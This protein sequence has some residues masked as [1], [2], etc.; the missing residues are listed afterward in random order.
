MIHFTSLV[1]DMA[2]LLCKNHI[3][4]S[5]CSPVSARMMCGYGEHGGP[6]HL[7]L[8]ETEVD[9]GKTKVVGFDGN[10]EVTHVNSV[11]APFPA[12]R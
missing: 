5:K 3:L 7:P 8:P 9:V 10:G 6:A 11:M 1:S 4:I 2:S 12:I